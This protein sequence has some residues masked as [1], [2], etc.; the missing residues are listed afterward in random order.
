[1]MKIVK[2]SWLSKTAKEAEVVISDGKFQC[3]AFAHPCDVNEEDLLK[4]PLHAFMLKD[5]MISNTK[6]YCLRHTQ[7][8]S[9]SHECIAE[10]VDVKKTLV[11]VGKIYIILDEIL[12]TGIEEGDFVEFVCMRFDLW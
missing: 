6:D 8:Q 3:V 11:R 12:P 5:L 4:E 2:L 10:V 9:L 7:A 1:M